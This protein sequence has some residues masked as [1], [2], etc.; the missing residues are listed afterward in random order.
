MRKSIDDLLEAIKTKYKNL[1]K[2]QEIQISFINHLKSLA[3]W[4]E[5]P[6]DYPEIKNV[7]FPKSIYIAYAVCHPECGVRDYIVDGSTQRCQHCGG[8][9]FRTEVKEYILKE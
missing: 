8:D 6:M 2:N 5:E 7:D 4:Y 1:P 3:R 9:L